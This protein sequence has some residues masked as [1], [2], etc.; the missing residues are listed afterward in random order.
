[1]ASERDGTATRRLQ[2]VGGGTYT[3]SIPKAWAD[4]RRLEAGMELHLYAHDDGSIVVRDAATD[5]DGLATARIA[6]DGTGPAPVERALRSAHAAG[7]ETVRLVP[8]DGNGFTDEQRRAARRVTR[9][10]VGTDLLAAGDEEIAVQHLLDA[11]NVSVR[12]S[13]HQLQFTALA[14]QDGAVAAVV[15][16]DAGAAE[17]LDE[18]REE[19]ARLRRMVERHAVRSLVSFGEVDRLGVSRPALFD[20]FATA[21]AL[22]RVADEGVRVARVAAHLDDGLPAAVAPTVRE[23]ADLAADVVESATTAVLDGAATSTAH[24]ALDDSDGVHATAEAAERAL[25]DASVD[26]RRAAGTVRTLDALARTADCGAAV[27]RTAL[28]AAT[29]ADNADRPGVGVGAVEDRD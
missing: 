14:V 21:R 26:A 3:V 18:R 17:R 9:T 12:Q 11:R 28:R 2:Q 8:D 20:C 10:L 15:D 27:A 13:V 7:F 5:G 23:T 6:V 1:M 22:E 4:E 19:A 29:R 16:G 25:F 24:D